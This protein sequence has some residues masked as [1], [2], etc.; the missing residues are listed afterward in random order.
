MVFAPAEAPADWLGTLHAAAGGVEL[1]FSLRGPREQ[2]E[3]RLD[4][5]FTRG[6]G[7]GLEQLLGAR[8][9]LV[10]LRGELVEVVDPGDGRVLMSGTLDA[11]D[12]AP[13]WQEELETRVTFLGYVAELE[14]WL[15]DHLFP[16]AQPEP[17]DAEVL[18][19]VIPLI[20]QPQATMT[21]QRV[22]LAPGADRPA[23]D[24]PFQ[25]ALLQPL[26]AR[27]F[28]Q[29]VYLGMELLHLPEAQVEGDAD[30]LAIVPAGDTGTGTSRLHHPDEAPPPEAAI[31]PA[32]RRG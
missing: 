26:H 28:G 19:T 3:S 10:A 24:G 4:W 16:P 30:Y 9:M 22:E 17:S 27:L 25:F 7:S 12:D 5:R 29:E 14:A 20:R 31:Q 1:F 8:L 13:A 2:I 32:D 6:E 15:G 18:S 23:D 21:W 11:P